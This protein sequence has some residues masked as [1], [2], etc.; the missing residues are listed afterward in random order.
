MCL[1]TVLQMMQGLAVK[2]VLNSFCN[3][4]LHQLHGKYIDK[5][6]CQQSAFFPI[7]RCCCCCC[8][9]VCLF[10]CLLACCCFLL[11]F[12]CLFVCF[13]LLVC[14]GGGDG[15][16]GGGFGGCM[17]CFWG[18]CYCFVCFLLLFLVVVVGG[19]G[20]VVVVCLFVFGVCV[21]DSVCVGGGRVC[22]SADSNAK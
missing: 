6:K 1:F 8:C 3:K 18:V 14:F 9:C 12:L 17:F 4:R 10:A 5:T 22:S 20:I 21:R 7:F 19:G 15:G 13:C 11:L 16:G 2:S